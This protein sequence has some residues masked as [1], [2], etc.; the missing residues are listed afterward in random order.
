[1]QGRPPVDRV[2]DDNNA[3][4]VVLCRLGPGND[5]AEQLP[6]CRSCVML[7]DKNDERC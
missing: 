5:D 4:H 7:S 3:V 6:L 2:I 1:M